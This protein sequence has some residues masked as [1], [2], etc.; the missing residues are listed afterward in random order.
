MKNNNEWELILKYLDNSLS[1]AEKEKLHEWIQSDQ[2]N[3]KT[4]QNIQHIWHTPEI[5]L[6]EPF[7]ELAWQKCKHA[8]GIEADSAPQNTPLQLPEKNSFILRNNWNKKLWRYAAVILVLIL[9]PFIFSL[10]TEPPSLKELHVQKAQK[11]E[12]T[13]SDGTRI[14]L[15]A[16]SILRYP[17][18]FN[19]Q[20]RQ[21]Y[22][23]GEGY[24]DVTPNPDLPFIIKTNNAMIRVLGTKF[25]VRAWQRNRNPRVTVAVLEGN[26]SL[27]A[28]N[29]PHASEKVIISAGQVSEL[30]PNEAPTLPRP[31]DIQK[32]IS[33][34]EREMHFENAPLGEVLDQLERW[35]NQEILL[36]DST[37]GNG[38]VTLYVEDKPLTETLQIIAMMNNLS[39]REEDH[40]IIFSYRE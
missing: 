17:E 38:R 28:E 19:A 13:L 30:I 35:Y 9:I 1:P 22:L 39:F 37:L 10:F 18:V 14:T 15:D 2:Q 40:K 16:G 33:W 25:N 7:I 23:N 20:T 11:M 31:A 32:Y 6:P 21:I 34:M 36:P 12:V 27:R 3:R 24:F 8:A 5:D 26:V 29:Q 4:L